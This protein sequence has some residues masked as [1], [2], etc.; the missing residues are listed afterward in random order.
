MFSDLIFQN[1]RRN[2]KENSLFFGSLV[3]SIIAF[4]MILSISSQDV[5][6]FLQKMESDAVNK[7][8]LLIPVFYGMS[9][10]ILFF[11]IYFACKYQFERRKHEFGLYLMLGMRRNRLFGMLLAEDLITSILALCIG[12]PTAVMLSEIIS[13]VTARFV[14][15]GIIGHHFSLSCFA[16]TWTLAG[17][18]GVKLLA[19]LILSGKISRQELGTLLSPLTK[20][21]EKQKSSSRY[22]LSSIVG[23]IMLACAY[24]MAIQGM[25]WQKTNMMVVT[26]LLGLTGTI[27]LFYGMGALI[28]LIV[29]NGK[30]DKELHVFTFRQIQENVIYQSNS[31][32]IS[33]LLILAAL[34][35][36]GAGVGIAGTNSLSSSHVIDYTFNGY[37]DDNPQQ[38]LPGQV[39]PAI[40][41]MLNQNGLKSQFSD[42]FEM[43]VGQ[44]VT[45]DGVE[46]VLNLD[47]V[48]DDLQNQPRSNT[49]DV[50]LNTL[51]YA[52]SPHLIS[53]SDY[54]HLLKLSGK[55]TVKLKENEA[56]VY[57]G[58]DFTNSDSTA[59]LNNILKNYPEVKLADKTIH[60]T[61]NVQSVNLITD[62]SINLS[63]ALILPDDVFLH[64]TNDM[65]E[66]YVNACLSKQAL[67]GK[68]L[69][70][71][72]LDLNEKLNRS[73]IE[74][75]SYL[76]NMGRQLF[77]SVAFSYITLYLAIV[78]LV[79]ANTI[80][81][82]QFLMNQQKT[83]RRYQTLIRLG[84]SYEAL[85]QS[86][87]KQITWFMGLPVLVAAINSFFGVKAL[88]AGILSSG[89]RGS[90][91]E[92]LRVSAGLIL[93]L[94]VIEYIYMRTVKGS[95]DRYL[96]TLM[97]PQREE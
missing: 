56:A 3:I 58:S 49:G 95:S 86:A 65:Y 97:Q 25:A 82:V 46:N 15:I 8:L 66:T 23:I 77:Y 35:C 34:C 24:Y 19:L 7:L 64:Y 74:Y 10:V 69:M 67:E 79:V 80:M 20:R 55:P 38:I 81:G 28:A 41:E 90:I 93:L 42:I 61:G 2:R 44:V 29:K 6:I 96:L 52:T 88:F 72:Y 9:L 57:M 18:L 17:F 92:M 91:S 51:E 87:A 32:A 40:E 76:Q 70:T 83:G 78:F 45:E 71:A 21:P 54:N 59:M 12:L 39:L 13:L 62:R 43:R 5:M 4:Y 31:M 27:L 33:S 50:L 73:G 16:I 14:G 48:I 36:F 37:V 26:L 53:L 85:C 75:E 22:C 94:C 47:S 89:I 11:L 84:A 60:L 30:S 63:F 1:S 68:S